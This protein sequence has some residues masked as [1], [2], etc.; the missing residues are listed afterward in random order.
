MRKALSII[1]AVTV[2]VSCSFTIK[3][4]I[5]RGNGVEATRTYDLPA[6]SEIFVAGS[7]DVFY[8][9]GP[10]SI[11]LT[12]DEN[13]LDYYT[14]ESEDNVLKISTK[15]GYSVSSKA[16]TFVTVSSE[17]LTKVK[18]AGS[19]ECDIVGTLNT[20]GDFSFSIAGSGDLDAD[21]IV[22]KAFS[23][24]ING[25]GDVEVDALTAESANLLINGSG[26]IKIKCKDAGDI[27][28]KINGSGDIALSGK[29]RS[30]TQKVN[31]AGD[32]S[33]KGL[34]LIP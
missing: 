18:L 27:T 34:Q 1:L 11:V 19:G 9:Q 3:S 24:K 15:S 7:M 14:V 28:A 12:A 22:C 13:L 25:S 29:A 21:A 8:T 6:F 31:G 2:A 17:D 16:K 10:Q 20:T 26:D 32:I 30:L 23:A 33:T 5:V 4:K